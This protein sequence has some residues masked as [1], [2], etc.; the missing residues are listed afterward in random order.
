VLT[1]AGALV[2]GDAT[3][4]LDVDVT[5]VVPGT[6]AADLGKAEDAVHASG[7]VGVMALAVRAD[8]AA[9]TGANGDYV[10]LLVDST[11]KLHV[12]V[13]NTSLAVAGAAAH[14]AA[15]SG[16]PVLGG[17][18]ARTSDG[19]PVTSGD[20]VRLLADTLGKQVTLIGATLDRHTRGL[21][22]YTTT[23]GADVIAAA[24][25][26][27]RIAVMSVLVVNAHAT[28][29]TKVSIRDGTTAKITGYA[30]A[31]GG[32]YSLNGGGVPLFISTANAAITA[33]CATTGAD[34]DVT[35]SGYLL[36]N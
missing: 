29:S 5:H 22:N 27:V 7:D 23:T 17:A 14:D 9:A 19:T 2:G 21:T 26:G 12:N 34:V 10:P 1:A 6:A 13:G 31:L 16:N 30:A 3:N 24:G 35:V 28:V 36:S 11:G 25:A 4:G 15:V 18:E 32:G 20:A 33:I 8:T